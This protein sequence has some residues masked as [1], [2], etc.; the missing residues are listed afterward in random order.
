MNLRP[1]GTCVVSGHWRA[2]GDSCLNIRCSGALHLSTGNEG[3]RR[4]KAEI[5]MHDR[6]INSNG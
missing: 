1:Q 5:G 6:R 2:C 4:P 3:K